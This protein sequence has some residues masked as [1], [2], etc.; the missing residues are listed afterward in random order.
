MAS[1]VIKLPA[2][3]GQD[4]SPVKKAFKVKH[5]K[6]RSDSQQATR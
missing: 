2:T 4:S 3:Q 1:D 6:Q 5:D